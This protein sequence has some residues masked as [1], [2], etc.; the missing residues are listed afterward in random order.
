MAIQIHNPVPRSHPVRALEPHESGAAVMTCGTC[1]RRWDDDFITSMTP[2]P[3]GR[4]PFE[5]FH[6]PDKLLSVVESFPVVRGL[7]L[8]LSLVPDAI[9]D[10]FDTSDA[11][12]SLTDDELMNVGEE[13]LDSQEFYDAFHAALVSAF[14]KLHGFD[15]DRE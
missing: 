7:P 5:E 9:R 3:A 10:H 6:E 15:P 8:R 4:C 2:A 13:V 12:E 11:V 14:V 1:G